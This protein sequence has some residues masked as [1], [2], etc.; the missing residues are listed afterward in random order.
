VSEL[1]DIR[2]I[3]A[4]EVAETAV[5]RVSE[6]LDLDRLHGPYPSRKSPGL[7]RYYLT[8]RLHPAK[9]PAL[10]GEVD[11]LKR[12][13]TRL[14]AV[15]ELLTACQHGQGLDCPACEPVPDLVHQALAGEAVRPA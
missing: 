13:V 4:P 14:R 11:R 7:A 3:G 12:Q 10:A 15:L 6:L 9:P 1:L 8:G 2:V 5:A